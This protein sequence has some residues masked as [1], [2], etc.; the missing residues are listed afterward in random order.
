M[1]WWIY[2]EIHGTICII[3]LNYLF[4]LIT[5]VRKYEEGLY[6]SATEVAADVRLIFGNCYR[7]W[8]PSD[9]LSNRALKLEQLFEQ[10]L[11]QTSM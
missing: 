1:S 5:V 8:G 7:Y 2:V 3:F 10:K 11:S 6:K 9:I 4:I